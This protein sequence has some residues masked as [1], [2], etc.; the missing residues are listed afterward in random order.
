MD[1]AERGSSGMVSLS[2][3]H[4]KETAQKAA[5]KTLVPAATRSHRA[6][7]VTASPSLLLAMPEL[8]APPLE[9]Q[10]TPGARLPR[11]TPSAGALLWAQPQLW[12]PQRTGQAGAGPGSPQ[13]QPPVPPPCKA[14][15]GPGAPETTSTC[16][17]GCPQLDHTGGKRHGLKVDESR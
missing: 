7:T 9:L 12:S 14:L 6:G 11:G 4:R 8:C 17:R 15:S 13:P 2:T 10:S 1:S 3:M 5:L 16:R